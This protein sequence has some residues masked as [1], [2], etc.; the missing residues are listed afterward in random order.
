MLGTV[1]EQRRGGHHDVGAGEEVLGHVV[2]GLDAGG[3]SE[4]GAHASMEQRDP[5]ARQPGLGGAREAD[6]GNDGER[7]GVDIGLQEPVEQHQSVRAGLVQPQRHLA[8]RAE[9]RTQLDRD[10][11][12]HRFLD[13]RQDV[14]VSLL[15]VAARAVRVAG[16]VVDVQ[17]DRGGAGIL[18]R[19]GVVR[20]TTRRDSVEAADYRDL[21]GGRRALEQAQ[22][23]PWAWLLFCGVGEVRERF[24]EAFAPASTNRSFCAAS[25]AAAPRTGSRGRP[26][27]RRRRRACARRQR[28]GTVGMP[29]RRAGCGGRGPGTRSTGPSP[30]LSCVGGEPCAP[31]VAISS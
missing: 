2:R 28:S 7:L 15:D 14:E 3:R 25:C 31:R 18:H 27:R 20:P 1:P 30:I 11:H 12:A 4:R 24:G 8:G 10:R 22:V 9:V 19:A 26:H 16:Q 17:L 6:P 5:R 23:A 29:M 21:D 13:A